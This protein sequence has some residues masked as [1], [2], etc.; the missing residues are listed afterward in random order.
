M[1]TAQRILLAALDLFNHHGESG[2]TSVDIALELDISPGNLYYHFKGK[3]LMVQALF[4]SYRS[5]LNQILE[6]PRNESLTIEEFFYYIFMILECSFMFRFLYRNPADLTEKYPKVARGFKQLIVEK[7][8]LL[9]A[10][11]NQFASNGAIKANAPQIELIAEMI[12]LIFTQTLNYRL[13]KGDDINQK[14]HIYQALHF[15]LFTLG[16]YLNMGDADY[17]RLVQS[18]AAHSDDE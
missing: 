11:L 16:P 18:L 13:L 15:M 1:K 9:K 3:E 14:D 5:E 2:V 10:R 4:E 6:A 17:T 12:A 7:E 8:Q